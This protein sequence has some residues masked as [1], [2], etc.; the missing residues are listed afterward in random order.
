MIKDWYKDL[1][2]HV[3]IGG[4]LSKPFPIERGIRSIQPS[5]GSTVDRAEVKED[6]SQC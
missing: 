4:Q 5:G 6:R 1:F 3:H 2:T